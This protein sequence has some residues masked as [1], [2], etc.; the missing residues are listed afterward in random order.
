MN[1]IKEGVFLN[2]R[3][4]MLVG[5]E[6]LDAKNGDSIPVFDPATGEIIANVPDAGE[7]DVDHA[8][9]TARRT[10]QSVAWRGMTPA[11]RERI[12]LRLADLIET[13][14]EELAMLE[15]RNNGKLLAYSRM[16]EVGASAQWLRY[17]AG[18]AT[19]L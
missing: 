9:E 13:N 19:K 1:V 17:M 8:V 2:L 5:G 6:W 12:L 14:G 11:A 7:V 16:F 4:R 10:Y 18:W 3:D 15:T